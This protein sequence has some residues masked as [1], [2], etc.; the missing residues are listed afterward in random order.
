MPDKPEPVPQTRNSDPA[1]RWVIIRIQLVLRLIFDGRVKAL[2][3]LF[4]ILGVFLLFAPLFGS[5]LLRIGAFLLAMVLFVEASPPKVV[6]EHLEDLYHPIGAKLEQPG[7]E[8]DQVIDA[9]F[10]EI[11]PEDKKGR[12]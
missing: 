11:P 2:F 3:K 1:T 8:E 12:S 7:D 10:R 4:P 9:E 5:I 6:R